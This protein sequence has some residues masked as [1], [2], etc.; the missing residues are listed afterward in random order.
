M[1]VLLVIRMKMIIRIVILKQCDGIDI[2][3][4]V[5]NKDDDYDYDHDDVDDDNDKR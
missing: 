4:N 5:N 1:A 2:G 3:D